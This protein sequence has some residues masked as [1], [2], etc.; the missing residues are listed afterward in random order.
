MGKGREREEIRVNTAQSSMIEK[1][2]NFTPNEANLCV[3]YSPETK[4]SISNKFPL[5]PPTKHTIYPASV[6]Q[7]Q[8]TTVQFV[9]LVI[10]SVSCQYRFFFTILMVLNNSLMTYY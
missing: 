1:H 3:N 2:P 5:H 10:S 9:S 7:E 4:S 8:I 6:P